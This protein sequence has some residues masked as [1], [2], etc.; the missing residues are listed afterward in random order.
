MNRFEN[1]LFI[2]LEQGVIDL[3]VRD[4][5]QINAGELWKITTYCGVLLAI[6]EMARA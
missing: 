6:C 5:N 3:F 4:Y 1:L 2:Y